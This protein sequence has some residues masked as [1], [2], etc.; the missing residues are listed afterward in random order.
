MV[1]ISDPFEGGV[2]EELLT[3]RLSGAVNRH[4]AFR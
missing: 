3:A 2:E 4:W 1:L